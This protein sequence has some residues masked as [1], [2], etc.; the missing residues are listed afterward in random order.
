MDKLHLSNFSFD[1]AII[2]LVTFFYGV[3]CMLWLIPSQ[4]Y[5]PYFHDYAEEVEYSTF[6]SIE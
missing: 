4:A 6:S 3:S 5:S 2:G 1:F